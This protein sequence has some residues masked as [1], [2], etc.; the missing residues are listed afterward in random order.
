MS[1]GKHFLPKKWWER[2]LVCGLCYLPGAKCLP[3][4][5]GWFHSILLWNK[6]TCML[7]HRRELDVYQPRERLMVMRA[8]M[9]PAGPAW[10][11]T[12]SGVYPPPTIPQ[13]LWEGLFHLLSSLPFKQIGI[14]WLRFQ[15]N[16]FCLPFPPSCFS[17]SRF[18]GKAALC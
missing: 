14:Q 4:S 2:R 11:I 18:W 1:A 13:S 8:G 9:T 5:F 10:G 16:R 17:R 3:G 12:D 15:A 7:F 6:C